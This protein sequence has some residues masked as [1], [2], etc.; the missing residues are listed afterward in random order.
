MNM[1]WPVATPNIH[2]MVS[3]LSSEIADFRSVF[4]AFISA[5]VAN[6]LIADSVMAIP[7]HPQRTPAKNHLTKIHYQRRSNVLCV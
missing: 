6:V 5:F 2:L 1:A 4:V 3:A 7:S